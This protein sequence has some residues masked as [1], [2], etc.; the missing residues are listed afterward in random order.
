ML[1]DKYENL[2]KQIAYKH[3]VIQNPEIFYS[4]ISEGI[5]NGFKIIYS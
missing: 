2:G 3:I 4:I 5:N 1:K